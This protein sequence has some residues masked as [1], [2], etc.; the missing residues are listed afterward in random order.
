MSFL[1]TMMERFPMRKTEEQKTKF[2]AWAEQEMKAL[3]Y[4]ARVD[5]LG[6]K[7]EHRNLVAGDPASA[8]VIFTA[9]Y[10]TPAKMGL[11]NLMLPRNFPLYILYILAVV[12]VLLIPS[13]F[14]MWLGRQIAPNTP[15]PVVLQMSIYIG[16]L[17]LMMRGPANR[18]N[19]NDNTSGVA[20]V[21]AL[22]AT[23]PEDVRSKAAFILFDNEEKGKLG[24]KAFA[25]A[26]LEVSAMKLVINLDCVGVGDHILVISRKQAT[27]LPAYEKFYGMLKA[28]DGKQVYYY[29]EVGSICN[30]D[31]KSFQCGAAIVACKKAPVVGFYTSRIHTGRDTIADE[32]NIAYL[33]AELTDFVRTL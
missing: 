19:A 12:A 1:S 4:N 10:D 14:G 22:M 5:A 32:A 9:H 7:N 23:L 21:M 11:P 8:E 29:P 16:L 20:A 3:G 31:H 28:R 18:H 30:S 33:A 26:N 15:L 6:P 17:V 25:K 13:F 24:S 27:Y 2:L